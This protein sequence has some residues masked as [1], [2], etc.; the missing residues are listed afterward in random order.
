[1]NVHLAARAV[2]AVADIAG[3]LAGAAR[4][5][6]DWQAGRLEPGEL[7]A[8]LDT[9]GRPE[10]PECLPPQAMP[11]RQLSSREN[12]AALIHALTHIEFNAID[13]ALDAVQRFPGLPTD[14]YGD[15]LKVAAEEA[16]HFALLREHLRAQGRDYGDFPAHGGLWEMTLKTAHD[17]LARMAL[18]PRLM[19][20]RGLDVTPDIQ[21][22]LRGFGD[23]AGAAVLD[24]IL[25]DEIGHVAAGDRWFRHL[26][27][28]RGLDVAATYRELLAL[29]GVPRPRPPF[30]E[31]AR[32]NA[33]FSR[34]E[35][36]ELGSASRGNKDKQV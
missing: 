23:A 8:P 25:R 31:A 7:G 17:P 10:K 27:H 32:L 28:A 3:K 13:L 18:V 24:I 29:P 16:Y 5:W 30:N 9:P 1:M 35:L 22:K 33:G 21:R 6:A 12:H 2:L 11:R 34:E 19:E 14:F 20:A 15:W 4:L 36:A 26:C